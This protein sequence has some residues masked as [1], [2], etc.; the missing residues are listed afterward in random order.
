MEKEQPDYFPFHPRILLFYLLCF[1]LI[2]SLMYTISVLSGSWYLQKWFDLNDEVSIPTWHSSSQLLVSGLLI[3]A[4]IKYRHERFSPQRGLYL[5]VGLGLIFLSADEASII[6][7]SLNSLSKKYATFVPL[8]DGR[9]G[10][11]ITLYGVLFLI[12]AISQIKN[13][14]LMWKNYRDSFVIFS[15]GLITLVAGAVLVEI[16]MYYSLFS[17]SIVQVSI[18]E[19][20]EM[21]G[22]S[23][24]LVSSL[25]FLNRHVEV[26]KLMR[27]DG[28]P[29]HFSGARP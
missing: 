18:E 1:N 8:F 28:N 24:I 6:H 11:W 14:E 10:A 19:F 25:V 23:I 26:R 12:I 22:G 27:S 17:S 7:E 13:I 5:I 3:L 29:L 16:T 9:H 20:L 21:A 2:L 15:V 4:A